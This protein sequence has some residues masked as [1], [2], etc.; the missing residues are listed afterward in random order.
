MEA[1]RIPIADSSAE[2]AFDE[3]GL[4]KKERL[5]ARSILAGMTA[6]DAARIMGLSTS[7]VGSLRQRAYR[8]LGVSGASEL[9]RRYAAPVTSDLIDEDVLRILSARGLGETQAKVLALVAAGASSSGI[10]QALCLAPGTV[11]SSRADGYRLLGIHSREEL[12]ELIENDR[13]AP[14]RRRRRRRLAYAALGAVL[15]VVIA[16]VCVA[17]ASTRRRF[18]VDPTSIAHPQGADRYARSTILRG[19]SGVLD[20]GTLLHAGGA[21]GLSAFRD[22][23]GGLPAYA[24]SCD[25]TTSR[26]EPSTRALCSGVMLASVMSA[27]MRSRLQKL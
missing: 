14:E 5:A 25:E 18:R 2:R 4:T 1:T 13:R 15:V 19:R 8:K 6:A 17:W 24:S 11:S 9:T 10:A 26:V 21:R 22:E 3:C 23:P 16:F 20:A 12:V 27:S 7:T